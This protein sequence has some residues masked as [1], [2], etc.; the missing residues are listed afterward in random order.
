MIRCNKCQ[1]HE[2]PPLPP[3]LPAAKIRHNTRLKRHTAKSG[4]ATYG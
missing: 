4:C 3:V 2:P 1:D